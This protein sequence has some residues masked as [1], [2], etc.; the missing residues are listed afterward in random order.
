[1]TTH[2]PVVTLLAKL[3]LSSKT[4]SAAY[5]QGRIHK[6]DENARDIERLRQLRLLS[7]DIRDAFQLRGSFR[8]FLNAALNNERLFA[9]GSNIGGHFQRLSKLVDEHSIAFQEGREADCERWEV[10]VR[11]AI[12]DIADA[13][14]DELNNLQTQVASRFAAVST[15]AEKKRQNLHYQQRTQLL[16]DL[17][18]SFHFSDIGEQLD[19]HEELALSFRS[20]LADRIPTFRESLLTILGTLN[21]Y[22]FDFRQ[23][24]ERAKR[25]RAFALHLNRHTDWQPKDWDEVA[26]PEEWL[27]YATPLVLQCH[28]DISDG[29]SEAV[30]AEIAR[31][32]PAMAGVRAKHARPAGKIEESS[33]NTVIEAPEPPIRRAVRQYF[34]KAQKSQDGISARQWWASNPIL[35]E[36][37]REDIWLLRVLAEHDNRGKD[38]A[39]VLRLNTQRDPVFN[40][41]V[42]INDVVVSRKAA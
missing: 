26:E 31:T 30:L 21:Q 38:A 37:A 22:L 2:D 13:I 18:E 4:I 8:Q 12:S 3:S 1:M 33:G 9:I 41:N 5:H 28:P 35:L 17:L 24:E 34:K 25:V 19:G 32:I 42:L 16:V 23:I 40:G 7:P 10:E 11:E 36:N 14:D 15:I 6:D 39:W 27:Q 29:E 20:L